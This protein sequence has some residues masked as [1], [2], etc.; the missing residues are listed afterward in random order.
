[1]EMSLKEVAIEIFKYHMRRTYMW[2]TIKHIVLPIWIR[3]K[4]QQGVNFVRYWSI[5][6][7]KRQL[8]ER[9]ELVLDEKVECD[10]C[11]QKCEPGSRVSKL[12]VVGEN[13]TYCLCKECAD[14]TTNS[15]EDG[16]G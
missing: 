15:Y 3:K 7:G 13:I 12:H 8:C 11:L 1:M 2:K 16:R 4:S 6:E 9:T 10:H 14:W 5:W